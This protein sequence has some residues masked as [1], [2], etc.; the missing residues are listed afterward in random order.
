MKIGPVTAARCYMYFIHP[1]STLS[2]AEAEECIQ[3][4]D[5]VRNVDM[6]GVV[7]SARGLSKKGVFYFQV[8]PHDFGLDDFKKGAADLG[9]P[10][11]VLGVVRR[12]S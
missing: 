10:V 2:Q 7:E 4:H 3:E 9:V 6:S 8:T 1:T 5:R 11:L 12:T